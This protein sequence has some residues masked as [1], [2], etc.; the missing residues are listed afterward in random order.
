MIGITLTERLRFTCYLSQHVFRAIVY[1]NKSS[2]RLTIDSG[3]SL[4]SALL[5]YRYDPE[6]SPDID[7]LDPLFFKAHGLWTGTFMSYDGDYNVMPV[8]HTIPGVSGVRPYP[9]PAK[10]YYNITI[11]GTRWYQHDIYIHDHA[12]EDFCNEKI[13]MFPPG[14][15]NVL[16]DG[17][18]GENGHVWAADAYKVSN[19]EK[20][21]RLFG[22]IGGSYNLAPTEEN[23]QTIMQVV[24]ALQLTE[25][26]YAS[27]V[28][29]YI[30]RSY[31]FNPTFDNLLIE[32]NNYVVT[33]VTSQA[34]LRMSLNLTRSDDADT[35]MKVRIINFD[36]VLSIFFDV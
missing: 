3:E 26:S 18:C 2:P 9:Y 31:I 17:V 32:I 13:P 1:L 5:T 28:D 23:D 11:D 36:I 14:R 30:S 22:G 7:S 12:E 20:S 24:G 27:G 6:I 21:D 34:M 35:W 25:S 8:M 19:H 15:S 10:A 29:Y 4:L 16:G 33:S